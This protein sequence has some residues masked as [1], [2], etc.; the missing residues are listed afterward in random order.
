MD[1]ALCRPPPPQR[2]SS[3][4]LSLAATLSASL[5]GADP[6]DAVSRASRAF[7]RVFTE[8]TPPPGSDGGLLNAIVGSLIMTV[9]GVADRRADRHPRR[10]LPGRIRPHE[11]LTVGHALHQRLLLSAPSIVDR[12][13]RL[14]GAGRPMGH[15]SGLAG[16][17]ALAIIVIPVVVR[18][19]EDMLKLVPNQLREAAAALG[20]AAFAM[21][22]ARRLPRGARRHHHRRPAGH[23]AHQRRDRAAALHR[24]QQ[25][26][27]EHQS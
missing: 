22:I 21:I 2:A 13:V 10:H 23:R 6:R 4:A 25:P 11:R 1:A 27:L 17:V 16:A 9:I 24:A 7:A 5:A 19:T 20:A 26:V 3:S 18:T 14:R 8:M 12:P 15:F